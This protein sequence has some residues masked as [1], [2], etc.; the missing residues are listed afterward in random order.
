[1]TTEIGVVLNLGPSSSRCSF[2]GEYQ[3]FEIPLKG[4][5]FS[6]KTTSGFTVT[7][8]FTSATRVTGKVVA[9][10]SCG[11]TDTFSAKYAG[12]WPMVTNP[13]YPPHGV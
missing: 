13:P 7:G 9:P 1:M 12:L 5:S 10:A 2:A 3:G 8:T 6:Q 11:G 4:K